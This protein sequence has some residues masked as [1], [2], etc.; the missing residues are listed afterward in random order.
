MTR[1]RQTIKKR[2]S[3]FLAMAM[4]LSL[5]PIGAFA[6]SFKIMEQKGTEAI[7]QYKGTKFEPDSTGLRILSIEKPDA[8]EEYSKNPVY[9]YQLVDTTGGKPSTID[10]YCSDLKT[11]C[12]E[13]EM[14]SRVPLEY[15]VNHPAAAADF[16]SGTPEERK[17]KAERL[18]AILI[19]SDLWDTS[20]SDLGAK[21]GIDGLNQSQVMAATQ[22]AIWTLVN[23]AKPNL[24]T[25]AMA[26]GNVEKYY[27]YLLKL[28]GVKAEA[29]ANIQP[30]GTTKTMDSSSTYKA[31]VKYAI[32]GLGTG[33]STSAVK[34]TATYTLAGQKPVDI[35][36]EKVKVNAAAKTVT[37]EGVPAAAKITLNLTTV[38][39]GTWGVYLFVP[40][41][42][43]SSQTLVSVVK[44]PV[45]LHTAI[46]IDAP[47]GLASVTVFKDW[48][49]GDIVLA[50]SAVEDYTAT[51]QFTHYAPEA[52]NGSFHGLKAAEDMTVRGNGSGQTG[53]VFEK[54]KS[55]MIEEILVNGEAPA[56]TLK[57][58]FK[59]LEG[60][61]I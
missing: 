7:Y 11:P 8:P 61:K 32:V 54:D 56:K 38:L 41:S 17:A 19:H 30:M 9:K 22:M 13:G 43:E 42:R 45:D 27:N 31:E 1:F 24:K 57:K 36:A 20:V 50:N 28:P 15:V 29:M 35:A 14:Y 59:V 47:V 53:Q 51:F 44:M 60:G 5:L 58:Y 46:D 6:D 34:A 49:A 23:N 16:F 26:N 40:S 55:Y 3:F 37:I 18:R 2:L 33:T 10:A 48:M 25:G 52:G 21:A 4:V 12:K 39:D